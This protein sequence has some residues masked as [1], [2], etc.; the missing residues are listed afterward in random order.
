MPCDMTVKG[1]YT[2]I[3]R[4]VL[5]HDVPV[6]AH[7]LAVATLGVCRVDK[8]LV[9]VKAFAIVKN[10]HVVAMKMHWLGCTLAYGF[11][12]DG[13]SA[14]VKE[15]EAVKEDG[16]HTCEIL[17]LLFTMKRTDFAF[18]G[19]MTFHSGAKV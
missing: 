9:V 16:I 7:H 2:W 1:P 14:A 12:H 17:E 5:H 18:P 11:G 8:R 10:I 19:C 6:G 4:I 13:D 3:I 15:R